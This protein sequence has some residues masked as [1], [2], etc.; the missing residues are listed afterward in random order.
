MK[1][2]PNKTIRSRTANSLPPPSSLSFSDASLEVDVSE[3][4]LQT[5]SSLEPHSMEDEGFALDNSWNEDVKT[6]YSNDDDE[7]SKLP[8]VNILHQ[9]HNDWYKKLVGFAMKRN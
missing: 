6:S 5:S 2:T 9:I 7:F 1:P 4:D 8:S 3:G